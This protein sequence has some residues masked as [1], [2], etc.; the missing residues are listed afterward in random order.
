MKALGSQS[1]QSHLSSLPCAHQAPGTTLWEEA[2]TEAPA[3]EH[4]QR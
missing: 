2:E 1:S 3:L 4:L